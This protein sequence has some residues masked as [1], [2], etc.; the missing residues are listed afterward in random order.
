MSPI[1][2]VELLGCPFDRLTMQSTIDQCL[3]WCDGPRVAHTV[4]TMNAAL[5]CMIRRDRSF[6]RRAVPAI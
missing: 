1:D 5:L 2:R 3:A 6:E 4:I